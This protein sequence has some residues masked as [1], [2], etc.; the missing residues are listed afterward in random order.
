MK[1]VLVSCVNTVYICIGLKIETYAEFML[2]T[3][4]NKEKI[5]ICIIVF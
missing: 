3:Q 2:G 5:N 4:L 1:I